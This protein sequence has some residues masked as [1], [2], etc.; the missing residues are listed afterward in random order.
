MHSNQLPLHFWC[1]SEALSWSP[2]DQWRHVCWLDLKRRRCSTR[3]WRREQDLTK[4]TEVTSPS[5]YPCCTYNLR[6]LQLH[7]SSPVQVETPYNDG[8]SWT[9]EL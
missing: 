9:R 3:R 5:A 1:F 8:R 2:R 6:T 4:Y 7:R